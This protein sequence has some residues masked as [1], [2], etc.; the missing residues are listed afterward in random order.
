MVY[1]RVQVYYVLILFSS[2]NFDE[3]LKSWRIVKHQPFTIQAF[4]YLRIY[5][6]WFLVSLPSILN[7]TVHT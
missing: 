2:E 1:C 4:M 5:I 7:F 6:E 3:L